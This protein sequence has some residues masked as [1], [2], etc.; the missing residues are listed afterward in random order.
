MFNFENLDEITRKYML[1]AISEAE[2]SGNIYFSTRFNDAG[3]EQWLPL[4]KE[5]AKEYNEHWLAYRLETKG[6]MKGL[7]GS[8]TPSGGYTYPD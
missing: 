5:A 7:E 8:M 2:A 4:L 6:L 1:E 3:Y